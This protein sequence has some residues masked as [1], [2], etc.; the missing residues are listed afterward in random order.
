[1]AKGRGPGISRRRLLQAAALAGGGLIAAGAGYRGYYRHTGR[2]FR[3]E[4]ARA[5]LNGIRAS[6]DP[7]A[8]PNVILI[9]VDDLGYGDLDSSMLDTP[10]LDRM[11]AEGT[12]L[13]SFYASAALCTPSRAGLLTGRYP[14]RSHMTNPLYPAGHPMDWLMDLL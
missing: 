4:R 13:T 9:L 14:V 1:M 7:S 2:D 12:R 11:A 10:N 6:D 8:L 3:P 5:Y